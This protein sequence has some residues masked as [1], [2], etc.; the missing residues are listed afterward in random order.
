MAINR[1]PPNADDV[2]PVYLYEDPTNY[3]IYLSGIY[4]DQKGIGRIRSISSTPADIDRLTQTPLLHAESNLDYAN[5]HDGGNITQYQRNL[6]MEN[7]GRIKQWWG[8]GGSISA[9]PSLVW[10][11][12][13]SVPARAFDNRETAVCHGVC[14]PSAWAIL[15]C[16]D[17]G[18][19]SSQYGQQYNDLFFDHCRE[20][21]W[22]GRPGRIIDGQHRIRGMADRTLANQEYDEKI[23]V[24]LMINMPPLAV[25]EMSAARMFIEINAGGQELDDKHKDYLATHFGI[26]HYSEQKDRSAYSI[27]RDLNR[28]GRTGAFREWSNDSAHIPK[29]GRVTMMPNTPQS[30]FLPAGQ[31]KKFISEIVDRQYEVIDAAGNLVEDTVYDWPNN[32]TTLEPTI[33]EELAIYLRAITEQWPG[34]GG[35]PRSAPKWHSNRTERGDLQIGGVI[36]TLLNLMPIIL[37]RIDVN[38]DNRDLAHMEAELSLISN[39]S[40]AGAWLTNLRGGAGISKVSSVLKRLL[41]AAPY[42]GAVAAPHWPNIATWYN[43]PHDPF[44][45]DSF[46]STTA[47]FD[48]EIET[49]C[50]IEPSIVQSL[51]LIGEGTGIVSTRITPAGGTAGA[52]TDN[53]HKITSGTN[54]IQYDAANAPGLGDTVEI[55]IQ[56]STALNDALIEDNDSI[57]GVHFSTVV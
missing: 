19:T 29:R 14:S 47:S 13:G 10:L 20:C 54:T 34:A 30:D 51:S 26:L 1:I 9:N 53:A 45:I 4:V 48:F 25:D 3:P 49:I 21:G 22:N 27:A 57:A 46:N 56:T 35:I 5:L 11:P 12:A 2:E 33:R 6:N 37:R 18:A 38:G 41:V 17:C 43:G 36:R 52:W 50:S 16:P 55:R 23:L 40:W 31:M 32:P 15:E 44:S 39:I 42:T 28:P 8:D 24:S 7:V